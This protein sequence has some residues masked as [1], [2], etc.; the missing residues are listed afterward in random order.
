[1]YW[2]AVFAGSR[3]V[4][5]HTEFA[6]VKAIAEAGAQLPNWLS[7]PTSLITSPDEVEADS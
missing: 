1:L 6:F 5:D 4:T 2:N 7:D 3:S